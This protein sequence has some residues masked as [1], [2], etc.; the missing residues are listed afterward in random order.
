MHLLAA[1]LAQGLVCI[2]AETENN[3]CWLAY[4]DV[5]EQNFA[6]GC[7]VVMGLVTAS[8]AVSYSVLHRGQLDPCLSNLSPICTEPNPFLQPLAQFAQN[9]TR[10]LQPLV[11]FDNPYPCPA[12]PC[13][14][15]QAV[16]LSSL[17]S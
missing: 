2:T 15:L 17:K 3:S 12:T 13:P 5:P 14:I 4:C 6:T 8:G 9:L 1:D 16:R 11:Q 7:K 10:F